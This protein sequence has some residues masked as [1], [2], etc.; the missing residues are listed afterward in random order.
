MAQL[1]RIGGGVLAPNL[2]RQ[3]VNLSFKNQI[4]DIPLIFLEVSNSN[5]INHQIGINTDILPESRDL[6]IATK[7]KTEKLISNDFSV[8]DYQINS[9]KIEVDF[10]NIFLSSTDIIESS[11]ITT[12]DLKI[13][14]NII[15]SFD[16]KNINLKPSGTNNVNIYSD[17]II[18][19][20]L[21]NTKNISMEGSIIFGDSSTDT[22]TIDS[23]ISSDLIPL[24]NN[25][26]IGSETNTWKEL[27]N[28]SV[29]ASTLSID[30]LITTIT[31]VNQITFSGNNI[32]INDS[33]NDLNLNISSNNLVS[34]NNI[35]YFEDNLIKTNSN[36]L[37]LV[38]TNNGYV[39]FDNSFGL[40]LPLIDTENRPLT[41]QIGETIYNPESGIVELWNGTNWIPSTGIS[42][43]VS[44]EE[45][46]DI[47]NEWTLILG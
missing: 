40:V 30:N 36:E 23:N 7:V 15:S 25:K 6:V 3:G 22:V 35:N 41:P 47:T 20:N 16:N 45:L 26:D 1:G 39:K 2:E 38:N 19:K 9:N 44:I 12:D 17:L 4:A 46:E 43:P 37:S 21:Y 14:N 24:D 13:Q 28:N 31:T 8:P 10:G 11:G 27:F 32:F 29:F 5:P 33:L 42:L 34:I 18:K